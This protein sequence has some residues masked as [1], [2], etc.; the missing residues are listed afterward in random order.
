MFRIMHRRPQ[1]LLVSPNF[2]AVFASRGNKRVERLRLLIVGIGPY[3]FDG[4]KL[5]AHS[6]FDADIYIH[7][8]ALSC[9][10]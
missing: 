1:L 6:V 3:H 9:R 7:F 10:R 8:V 4:I 2:N 5:V